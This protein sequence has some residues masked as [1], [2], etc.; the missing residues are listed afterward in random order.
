[1]GKK[2]GVPLKTT[3]QIITKANVEYKYVQMMNTRL[4]CKRSWCY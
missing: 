4:P 3:E 2:Y 1:M